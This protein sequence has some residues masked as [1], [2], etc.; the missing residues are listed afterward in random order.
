MYTSL[1]VYGKKI[2]GSRAIFSDHIVQVIYNLISPGWFATPVWGNNLYLFTSAY[3]WLCL[4]LTIFLSL[5]PRYT[6]KAYRFGFHPDDVDILRYVRKTRPDLDIGHYVKTGSPLAALKR[7]RPSSVISH[8]RRESTGYADSSASLPR[9][10]MDFRSASRTDMSTGIR[11]VHRGFDFSTEENGVAIRRMQ[12]NL[13]ERRISSRNLA[14]TTSP[15]SWTIRSRGERIANVLTA[16]RNFL[17]KKASNPKD[18]G[19]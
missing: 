4:P 2:P 10:S 8:S 7:S 18:N 13:S 5:L 9:H 16:P 1:V 12:T 6:Y 17:R 11:S 14:T 19:T 3:F 15:D